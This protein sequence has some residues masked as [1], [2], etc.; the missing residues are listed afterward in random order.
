[1]L[2]CCWLLLAAGCGVIIKTVILIT[3]R[4]SH[5]LHCTVTRSYSDDMMPL[6]QSPSKDQV[7]FNLLFLLWNGE[8]N[9]NDLFVLK[10]YI[11][12]VFSSKV[13]QLLSQSWNDTKE[14]VHVSNV[15]CLET[16]PLLS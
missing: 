7:R 1:M 11:L 2:G 13:F 5:T 12:F 6:Q 16:S 3:D 9:Y 8:S 10:G 14:R 4:H 15:Q